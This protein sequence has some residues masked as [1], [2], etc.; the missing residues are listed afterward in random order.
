MRALS[1]LLLFCFTLVLIPKQWWHQCA[2][3]AHK[4]SEI[5][6]TDTADEDCPV[7]NLAISVFTS[8]TAF[9]FRLVKQV[10]FVHG[11]MICFGLSNS[12]FTFR[13][14]RAPPA[15]PMLNI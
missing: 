11:Q 4:K 14:L 1:I 15:S 10:P 2:H 9:V 13:Q 6:H 12:E 7:C 3:T 5:S 8:P